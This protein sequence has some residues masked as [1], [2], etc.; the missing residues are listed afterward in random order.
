MSLYG[1]QIKKKTMTR[2]LRDENS[3]K[4]PCDSKIKRLE[5][6]KA[7]AARQIRAMKI[8]KLQEQQEIKAKNRS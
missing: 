5:R 7:N 2:L 8:S 1:L 3:K 6:A 4:V